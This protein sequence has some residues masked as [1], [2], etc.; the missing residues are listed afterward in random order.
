M[1]S[2]Q[3]KKKLNSKNNN[4]KDLDFSKHL[5]KYSLQIIFIAHTTSLIF[6][7]IL[8]LNLFDSIATTLVHYEKCIT[9]PTRQM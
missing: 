2:T 8:S 6:E 1:I 3:R 9:I 7:Y 4:S 5:D